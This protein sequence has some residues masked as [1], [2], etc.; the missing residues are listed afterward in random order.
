MSEFDDRV[1]DALREP[2]D[3]VGAATPSAAL[4]DGVRERGL[5]R[6]RQKVAALSFAGVTTLFV[7]GAFAVTRGGNDTIQTA[8][9]PSSAPTSAPETAPS[10]TRPATAA[11]STTE[12][13]PT[14][15]P[16][17]ATTVPPT[18]LPATTVPLTT[19]PSTTAPPT[20]AAPT[21]IPPPTTPPTTVPPPTT[22]PPTTPPAPSAVPLTA[23]PP[24][25]PVTSV[26]L[27]T[28]SLEVAGSWPAAS[29]EASMLVLDYANYA[30]VV[31]AEGE[32]VVRVTQDCPPEQS[33]CPGDPWGWVVGSSL[34][35]A[36][37]D[38]GMQYVFE[39]DLRTGTMNE[40]MRGGGHIYD[41]VGI[42]GGIRFQVTSWDEANISAVADY[43][44]GQIT[45]V[46]SNSGERANAS[47][48]LDRA[49]ERLLFIEPPGDGTPITT[50]YEVVDAATGAVVR[51]GSLSVDFVYLDTFEFV[52][53]RVILGDSFIASGALLD[54]DAG[55]V[56][57]QATG[58]GCLLADGT[59]VFESRTSDNGVDAGPLFVVGADGVA[60]EMPTLGTGHNE[61]S[62]SCTADRA[63]IHAGDWSVT[64]MTAD[65]ST[66]D[67]GF[68]IVERT[69]R[70]VG[71]R[72]ARH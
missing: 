61:G 38:L 43:V 62:T 57:Y 55:G 45:P 52:G 35:L 24:A 20:T 69:V 30:L 7:V 28:V 32:E 41:L 26:V 11:P 37:D 66:T 2:A 8:T 36:V 40:R 1:S 72:A 71:G 29:A 58:P 34:W 25:E 65:G 64:Y 49:G 4:L 70:Q 33:V 53:N 27:D 63:V 15:E 19:M 68:S 47:V 5:R 50:T 9:V 48:T 42:E 18:S 56:I 60:R 59:A 13:A 6:R 54:L 10:T 67:A 12:P 46:W 16:V 17:A 31:L 44:D 21:T 22:T 14:S 39:V 3:L 23:V 51:A